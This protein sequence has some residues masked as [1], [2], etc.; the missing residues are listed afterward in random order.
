VHPALQIAAV[1]LLGVAVFAIAHLSRRRHYAKFGPPPPGSNSRT[2]LWF[3]GCSVGLGLLAWLST[4]AFWVLLVAMF[5][6]S[7]TV[8]GFRARPWG[9]WQQFRDGALGAAVITAPLLAIAV[10]ITRG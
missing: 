10:V 9:P 3:F 1:V 2:L 5:V 7:Q 8:G 4:P 6:A